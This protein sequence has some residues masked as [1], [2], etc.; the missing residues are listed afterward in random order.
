MV[1]SYSATEL[2]EEPAREQLVRR[3]QV[4][5]GLARLRRV[6]DQ[7]ELLQSVCRTAAASCAFERVM[8]SR[9]DDD[10]WLPLRGFAVS[11]GAAERAFLEWIRSA[12]RIRLSRMVLENEVVR[13]H[14]AAIVEDAHEDLRVIRAFAR[15]AALR[16][17]VVAPVVVGGRVI[18]LLHADNRGT[19]LTEVDR[20]ALTAFATGFAQVFERAMLLAR[21]RE[22][23]AVV[24]RSM[25]DMES[26]LDQLAAREIEL[27]AG[28]QVV[29][30]RRPL[31]QHAADPSTTLDG[32]LTVRE[33]EVLVLMATGATND[34]IAQRLVIA[35]GTVKSHV[36]QILRKLR[37]ENRGEAIAHYLLLSAA[38]GDSRSP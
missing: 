33:R 14:E 32:L 26:L 37:V 36:K 17:Y 27:V 19:R 13:G 18:G 22:Q 38:A 25:E 16:S 31:G 1:S 24:V 11:A 10:E 8:L 12:P 7:D 20:D 34:R 29:V 4:D 21:L 28:D 23:R 6:V 15:P 2:P 3:E 30:G 9:I 5:R 35:T